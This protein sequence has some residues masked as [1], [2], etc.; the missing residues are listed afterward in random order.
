LSETT[1]GQIEAR[2]LLVDQDHGAGAGQLQDQRGQ[3]PGRRQVDDPV[4]PL[5]AQQLG[6]E[7]VAFT[8]RLRNAEDDQHVALRRRSLDPLGDQGKV[9]VGEFGDDQADRRGGVPL[10]AARR[11]VR[12]VVEDPDRVEDTG[13][14]IAGDRAG[15]IDDVS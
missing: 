9:L 8:G 10:Q 13:A 15:V 4:E 6:V 7:V 1:R 11:L 5:A 14:A 12:R 3:R 2:H